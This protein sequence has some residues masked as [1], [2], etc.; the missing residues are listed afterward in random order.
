MLDKEGG[1]SQERGSCVQ[2]LREKGILGAPPEDTQLV[3][4]GDTSPSPIKEPL[5]K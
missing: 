4:A 5:G 3:G 2:R 1:H